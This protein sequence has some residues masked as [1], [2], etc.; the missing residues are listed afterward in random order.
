[1]NSSHQTNRTALNE[2]EPA[3]VLVVDDNEDILLAARML[4]KQ[5]GTKIHTTSD[6]HRIPELMQSE[7]FDVILLDMNFTQ[8]VS[9]GHEGF[10]WLERILGIDPEAVVVLITAYG[11]VDMAAR[12]IQEG[13]TDFVLKPWQNEKL[14]A[15]I[16]A[17]A[18]L[19]RSR[20]EARDL[21]Q[22]QKQLSADLDQPFHDII[23]V[24]APMKYVFRTIE[25]V[26][27][28]DANVLVL[29]ENGTGKELV[30][31]AIHRHSK[32]AK[33]VFITVDMGALS[34][35]LFESE[36]FGYVRGAFTDAREDRA[37]R[38]ETADKGTLFL[39][40]I[41]NL[42]VSL[43]AKLL[44]VLEKRQV[45]RL[46]S[47]VPKPIDIRL[48]SAT[49]MPTHQQVAD[50]AFRQDLLY[51]LNTVEIH[52]PSLRDRKEDIPLLANHF[53]KKY[54]RKY[55]RNARRI[56]A[57][58][59][60]LLTNYLW[61]GNVRELQHAIERAVIMADGEVL[62]RRDFPL[63]LTDFPPMI[64][65]GGN[66]RSLEQVE[67]AAIVETLRRHGNN[68]SHAARELG[69]TRASLYRRLKKYGF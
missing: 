2:Q 50:G 51:R 31:R 38:F 69:L 10:F 24:S 64:D 67:R 35:T 8:D 22:R 42:P 11:D 65:G 40:E 26:A 61:P 45:T 44:S 16:S 37:G 23:G 60:T 57:S 56:D 30:A 53:V 43:Q 25:K 66:G 32:R 41:G 58:A 12:A 46:G 62:S 48:V 7:V 33:E 29:G 13:A 17:A 47:N 6:P 1:M 21:R 20:N 36:L 55:R 18:N 4:M 39:D 3:R 19:R 54:A 34:G 9:G 63:S 28:T 52:L 5:H 59:L 27:A 15:T 14:R 68:V 49:N